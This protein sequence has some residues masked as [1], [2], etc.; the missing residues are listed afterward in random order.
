M[1]SSTVAALVRPPMTLGIF[2]DLEGVKLV[3]GYIRYSQTDGTKGSLFWRHPF[4][5]LTYLT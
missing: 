2:S 4:Q 3:V 1:A 5:C